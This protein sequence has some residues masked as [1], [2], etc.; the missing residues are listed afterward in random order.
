MQRLSLI[1]SL[2]KTPNVSDEAIAEITRLNAENGNVDGLLLLKKKVLTEE[3]LLA[4]RA[5]QYG[6][7]FMKDLP[8]DN[9]NTEFAD[10][11]PIQFLKKFLIVPLQQKQV[12]QGKSAH[13]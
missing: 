12:S 3:Q 13:V 7:S 11:V 5:I 1:E 4:A 2:Q 8:L 9:I 10:K 6:L